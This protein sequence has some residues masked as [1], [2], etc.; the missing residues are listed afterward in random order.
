MTDIQTRLQQIRA[1]IAQLAP[2][3]D[4]SALEL[5]ARNILA[6]AKNTAYEYEAQS[7]FSLLA[8]RDQPANTDSVQIKGLIRRARIRIEI[9][10]D[11][12]DIDEAIDILEQAI[13]LN[14]NNTE[15]IELLAQAAAHNSQANYRVNDLYSR[16]GIQAQPQA[17]PGIT[18]AT[19]GSQSPISPETS[20]KTTDPETASAPAPQ[21]NSYSADVDD[22]MREMTE[23]YY[24]GDYQQTID[25]A[26]RVLSL[27]RDNPA[28]LDYRQKAEDNIVRGVV[29]DHRIPFEARVSYNRANSLVRA[30]N[31]EDAARLYRE[32]RELAETDGILSWKDVEQALL[33][34]QDLA[35]ARE[36][37]NDGD[38]SMA[39]D[40]WNEA[41]RKYEGALRV[42]PNDP[43]AEERIEMVRKVQQ[44][45]DQISVRLN[46]LNGSLEEQASK[47]QEIRNSLA[48]TSQLLPNSQRLQQ[49][50]SDASSRLKGVKAQ[51]NDQAQSSLNRAQ[52][53]ISLEE[54]LNLNNQAIKLM[55]MA[56]E[57][58]PNDTSTAEKLIS[59]RANAGDMS[60]ARQMIERASALIAQN[61]D[62]ELSQAR[63]MLTSLSDYAQDERYRIV[64]GDLMARYME[65]AEFALEEGNL[66]EAQTWLDALREEPF[67]ILG[68]RTEIF[69]LENA[70]KKIRNRNRS[71][72][73]FIGMMIIV[74]LCGM[75]FLTRNA[76]VPLVFPPPSATATDTLT[77]SITPTA[78]DTPLPSETFTPSHTPSITPSAT[79]TFTPSP[80]ITPSWTPTASETPTHTL[81]PTHTSTPTATLTPSPTGTDTP[82]PSPTLTPLRLCQVVVIGSDGIFMR[83][84]P[85]TNSTRLAIIQTGKAL[86]V[87]EQSREADTDNGPIWYRV[88]MTIDDSESLGWVRADLVSQITE[89]PPLPE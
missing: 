26:N 34:I 58:D 51:L 47:L 56:V 45:T 76:W 86:E 29:P 63:S 14:P 27:M 82:I 62:S 20:E 68:R 42:V 2:N 33:D 18:E 5:E 79:W 41:L 49:L 7:V 65:R 48:R 70:I 53:A 17:R 67:R 80:T 25:V 3:A 61:F 50:Q 8:Q 52:N 85:T 69:R 78:S 21:G 88:R 83:S 84:R 11:A 43:Q 24:A 31:Y 37:L 55:E 12:D 23:Y 74:L 40:N 44:E 46:M 13:N 77:P 35:L 36:L 9:A 32:A 66:S 73:L 1:Q 54:R 64:V 30:G 81:T 89:C 60:H 10:G 19:P 87:L 16:Y 15:V 38:R 22:L 75:V 39:S 4:T 72:F 57:L 28:A 71:I 6:D 59:S